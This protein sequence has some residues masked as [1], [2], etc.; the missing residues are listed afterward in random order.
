MS[1]RAQA[2]H[3]PYCGDEDLRPHDARPGTWECRSCQRI[4]SLTMLGLTNE[5]GTP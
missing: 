5:G 2:N 4:F 1:Q 3:C